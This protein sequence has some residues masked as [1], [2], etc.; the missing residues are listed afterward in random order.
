MI[1]YPDGTQARV[2]DEVALAHG[3][4][5]GT[6]HHVIES[7]SDREKWNL[8]QPGL[9]IDTSYGGFV[10]HPTDQLTDDEIA[11]VSRAAA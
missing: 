9:L 4:H 5:R 7:L 6:V 11:F 10:F 8:D 1:T 2:G 3:V